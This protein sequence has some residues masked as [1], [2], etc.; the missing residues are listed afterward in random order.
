MKKAVNLHTRV[1][2]VLTIQ[3]LVFTSHHYKSTHVVQATWMGGKLLC[4]SKVASPPP[5]NLTHRLW[6]LHHRIST[7]ISHSPI[8]KSS[9]LPVIA[10]TIPGWSDWWA[11]V[12]HAVLHWVREK[13]GCNTGAV[14]HFNQQGTVPCYSL[15]LWPLPCV[16]YTYLRSHTLICYRL[17]QI[18]Q[19]SANTVSSILLQR[20]FHISC[21][22]CSGTPHATWCTA[23]SSHDH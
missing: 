2:W 7:P 3:F 14:G 16:C 11:A 21:S 17:K 18:L 19:R 6:G 4:D 13:L 1:A 12:W 23:G 15:A 9:F 22:Y 8:C 10:H 5:S 20:L